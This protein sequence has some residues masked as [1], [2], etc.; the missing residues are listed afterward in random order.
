MAVAPVPIIPTRF[1][2]SVLASSGQRDVWKAGPLKSWT[3][4]ITGSVAWFKMPI[5]VIT[6]L[7]VYVFPVVSVKIQ[8]FESSRQWADVMDVLNCMSR[9]KLN[10]CAKNWQYRRV[11][12]WPAKCS[13]QSHSSSN[14]CE[15]E[16]MYEYD[17]ESNLAP[18]YLFLIFVI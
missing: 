8:E 10:F 6:N 18:G 17:S 11:S 5:A 4:G 15:K 13:V 7:D 1:P 14:S 9:F 16:K 3:P 2:F 12:A